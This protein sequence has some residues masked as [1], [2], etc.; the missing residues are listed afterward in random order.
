MT[1]EEFEIL[2][3]ISNIVTFAEGPGVR[4][5]AR[6]NQQYAAG[7]RVRWRHSKGL[8][9]VKYKSGEVWLVELHW[10]EAHGI[11]RC[12]IRDKHKLRRLG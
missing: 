11:G 8:A 7:R 4:V 12:E 2:S 1:T 6:L 3:S 5:R 9:E 10:F